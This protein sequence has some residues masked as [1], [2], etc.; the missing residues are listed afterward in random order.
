MLAYALLA[1]FVLSVISAVSY[2][3]VRDRAALLEMHSVRGAGNAQIFED[4]ISQTLQLIENMISTLPEVYDRPLN[5]GKPE[6]LER[7]LSRLLRS[8]PAVRSLSIL[9]RKDGV[10]A[11]SNPANTG[12]HLDLKDFLPLDSEES[13]TPFLR[14]GQ[15]W[16]GRDL[17]DGSPASTQAPGTSDQAYFVPLV[18]R[19]GRK[20]DALWVMAVFNPEHLI[21]QYSR[22]SQ[23]ETDHF[24]MVRLDGSVLVTTQI[25]PLGK[26]FEPVELLD[27]IQLE[28]MGVTPANLVTERLTAFR[29]SNRYPFFV[30]VHIDL[31]TTL[32]AWVQK[33]RLIA[34]GTLFALLVV[35]AATLM[36]MR[37]IQKNERAKRAHRRTI[38]TLSQAVEQNPSGVLVT[39]TRGE[40]DYC[41]PFFCKISGFKAEELKG[42]SPHVLDAGRLSASG[43]EEIILELNSGHRWSGEFVLRHRDGHEYT[44]FAVLAPLRDERGVITH[45]IHVS[46][47]ISEQKLMQRALELERDRAEAATLAKSQFLANMSHEIRTPM[48]GVIGLT[49]LTLETRLDDNQRDYLNAVR[50]SAL[51][52]MNILNDVL[53]FSKIEAGKLDT[54]SVEFS[55]A[56]LMAETGAFFQARAQKKGVQFECELPADL[57]TAMRGDPNRLRQVLNNLCDNALKFTAEGAV[58][59]SVQW[60]SLD[61]SNHEIQF[62]VKDS[63]IGIEDDKKLKVFE[64]FNQGDASTT[65]QYGG[66]G[67]GLAICSRLVDLMGGRIWLESALGQGATFFFTVRVGKVARNLEVALATD[68][69]RDKMPEAAPPSAL[70]PLRILVAEDNKVNQMLAL[71]LLK[72]WGH[73]V[74]VAENGLRAVEKAAE[75][76]WDIVLMDLQMPL[77][78]GLDATQQIRAAEQPGK[79]VPIIAVTAN[80]MQEDRAACML[81]GMDDFLP[82]PLRADDLQAMLAK[83]CAPA[84]C[85]EIPRTT[86]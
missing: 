3:I 20:D 51:S 45:H 49:E 34:L 46:H 83:H 72:R 58:E 64:A 86:V 62:S 48:N 44:V 63:G 29:N 71:T 56:A 1:L 69:E 35:M 50:N 6:D 36:M 61:D 10:M 30:A 8:Q 32:L 25:Q 24:E 23:I 68:A 11:S 2:T 85:G 27:R 47:D 26:T 66:T 82:K 52:L 19:L 73:Q 80:V 76:D 37:R 40:I 77:M 75:S 81:A 15:V 17:T 38:Q 54:E 31:A 28:V 22:Y 21:G 13:E 79:R 60:R 41:N 57:P 18:L 9:T 16:L 70:R 33:V 42:K 39:N 5:Q 43:Y 55:L 4:Q 12:K 65:R 53:D 14:I 59:V 84:V 7:L 78:G 74:E 67:L